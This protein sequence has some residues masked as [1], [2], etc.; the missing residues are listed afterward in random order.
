MD[1]RSQEGNV[2]VRRR[3]KPERAR[4]ALLSESALFGLEEMAQK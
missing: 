2:L 4:E 3:T 1:E